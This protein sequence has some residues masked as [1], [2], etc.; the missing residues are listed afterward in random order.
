MRI[1]PLIGFSSPI[2]PAGTADCQSA[3]SYQLFRDTVSPAIAHARTQLDLAL[4]PCGGTRDV[5]SNRF[6]REGA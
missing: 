2:P 4:R 5:Y 1:H 6:L 3:L